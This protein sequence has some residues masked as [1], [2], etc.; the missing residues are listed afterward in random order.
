MLIRHRRARIRL[1]QTLDAVLFGG[2]LCFAY[3]LRNAFPLWKLHE[4]EPFAEYLTLAPLAMIIGPAMLSIQGFYQRPR[5]APR[6][7]VLGALIRGCAFTVFGVILFLF[8]FRLQYARSVVIMTGVF[9][10]GLVYARA[11]ITRRLDA[12][13]RAQDQ[14]CRRVL[15]VGIPEMTAQLRAGLP[16]HERELLQTVADFDPRTGPATDMVA[17]LHQHSINLVVIDL[18]GLSPA[19]ILP[20]LAACEREGVEVMVRAGIFHTPVFRP[21]MDNLAGEPVIYYRAQ[22]APAGHLIAK[23][24]FD[25]IGAALLLGLSLPVLAIIGAIIKLTF[26]R[27]GL[28]SAAPVRTEWPPVRY[29][30]VP[31]DGLRRRDPQGRA[32]R[33]QRNEGTRFQSPR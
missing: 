20:V 12:S 6:I 18:L 21:E 25:Y 27:A 13:R 15:W 4:L 3:W 26:P 9:A 14:L 11:E 31:L 33:P 10:A 29:G 2:S 23:R 5:F 30:Q 16:A 24:L 1:L 22:A 19:G 28:L 7:E 17:L 8:L 32:R